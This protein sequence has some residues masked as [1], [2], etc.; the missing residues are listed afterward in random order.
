MWQKFYTP[1]LVAEFIG[2]LVKEDNPK[3]AVDICVGSWNL[4]RILSDKWS[5][6]EIYGIDIDS[7]SQNKAL[8]GAHF[9]CLDGREYALQCLE[10]NRK[11]G[12]VLANPPFGKESYLNYSRYSLL[13]GYKSLSKSALGRIESTM[14]LANLSLVEKGGTLI[15]IVPRTLINGDWALTLRKFVANNYFLQTIIHLPSA[16]F[17][18]DI[19]TSIIVIQNKK[20]PIELLTTEAYSARLIDDKGL[21]ETHSLTKF[22]YS[23]MIDGRWFN[24]VKPISAH[25]DIQI[26]RGNISVS[27]LE[28][29]GENPVIHSSDI[30]RI[31]F[32][33]WK[34]TRFTSLKH[35][36]QIITKSGDIIMVRVGRN[37][38][39]VTR[40]Q[41][42]I[43]FP[44]SDCI[45]I[46]R[47][48]DIKKTNNLWKHLNSPI[49][50]KDLSLLKKGIGS[51]YISKSNLNN[52][53]SASI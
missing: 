39:Q 29:R 7:S 34:P 30:R 35:N 44:I 38:G 40:A 25:S 2:G 24:C 15:A 27:E 13:P 9:K 18:R 46:I 36:S 42:H 37:C 32:S 12:I 31:G 10:H 19:S 1:K 20:L 26:L 4:L 3:N 53:L 51:Q 14:L 52:Y 17:G 16:V 11:F 6:I 5:N 21:F 28:L 49:Y 8:K 47:H 45:Y 33:G 22:D 48:E 23:Q 43:Q 41:G 50:Q